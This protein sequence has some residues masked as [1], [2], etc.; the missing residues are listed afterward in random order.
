M[1]LNVK[2]G[3]LHEEYDQDFQDNTTTQNTISSS[4]NSV[5]NNAED[6]NDTDF[7][8]ERL[9]KKIEGFL[10]SQGLFICGQS[11][12]KKS[13]TLQPSL[14]LKDLKKIHS[15][16]L[17]PAPAS[18]ETAQRSISDKKVFEFKAVPSF[19]RNRTYSTE[20]Y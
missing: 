19:L 8:P 11:P 4:L 5:Q 18:S 1:S 6:G 3:L 7:F 2:P 10:D 15:L 17:K 14:G 9:Y 20:E 13:V 16:I 12:V